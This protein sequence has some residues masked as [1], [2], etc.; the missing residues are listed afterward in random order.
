MPEGSRLPADGGEGREAGSV[1]G[2]HPALPEDLHERLP[3]VTDS[4]GPWFRLHPVRFDPI[5]FGKDPARSG[6]FGAPE[7]EYGVL[8]AAEDKYGAF[9]ETFGRD[10]GVRVIDETDLLERGAPRPP[11]QTGWHPLPMPTRS[12]TGRSGTLRSS[13]GR[14]WC[15]QP[16]LHEAEPREQC[17]LIP[18]SLHLRFRTSLTR[19]SSPFET[20]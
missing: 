12:I 1:P 3:T 5:H 7:G 10:M 11:P 14:Y 15:Q 19:E 20:V 16:A 13:G 9:V 6:R 4:A 8:Y 2:T 18:D 17:S